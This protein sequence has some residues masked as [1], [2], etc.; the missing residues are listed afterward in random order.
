MPNLVGSNINTPS[1]F[2]IIK[3]VFKSGHLQ[4]VK[5]F[6]KNKMIYPIFIFQY[7]ILYKYHHKL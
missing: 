7:Y 1:Y 3:K 6:K 2:N 5:V 4:K